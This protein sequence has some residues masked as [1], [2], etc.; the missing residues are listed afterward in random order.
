MSSIQV[1]LRSKSDRE[2]YQ[3]YYVDPLTGADVTR[4]AGTGN[5]RSA[6]RAAAA[7]EAELREQGTGQREM[8]WEQF[9]VYYEDTHLATK[10]KK[11]QSLGATAMNWLERAIGKPRRID[12]I[13]SLVIARMVSEW[14]RRKMSDAS[15]GAYL[16]H[17]RMAFGWAHRMHLIR[18]RPVFPIPSGAARFMRGRPIT[19]RECRQLLRACRAARPADWRQWVRFYRGLWLSG[20]RLEEAVRLSWTDPPLRVDLDGGKHPA[21]VIHAAG[22]KS[23]R[24]EIAPIAPDFAAWLRRTPP[25]E[26]SGPVL[27]LWSTHQKR[28]LQHPGKIGD[29]L[30]AIGK[31]SGILVNDQGKY[32]SAHDLRR[33]FGTRWAA[34]VKPLTLKRLMRHASI[35]TTLRYYVRQ[36]AD[37]VAEELWAGDLYGSR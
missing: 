17:L 25:G 18:Q 13:D 34:R 36:D 20:L 5:V 28:R 15:I 1:R 16:G 31:E 35:D 30:A 6:E 9:R 8:S 12:M 24:D 4:S 26:R 33:S 7:W 29:Y 22:Q 10:S 2:N 23:R 19:V 11:T 3:M 32:V 21:M 37:D 14:R 27:P